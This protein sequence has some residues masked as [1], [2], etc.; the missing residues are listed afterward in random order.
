MSDG[1]MVPFTR[2]VLGI[3]RAGEARAMLTGALKPYG[4]DTSAF[5]AGIALYINQSIETARSS[6]KKSIAECTH[7]SVVDAVRQWA[8]T[9]LS[10]NVALAH[11]HIVPFGQRR[12]SF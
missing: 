9:G 1:V 7:E 11:A 12:L 8:D 6:D 4:K 2:Q 5:L 3:C 10:V